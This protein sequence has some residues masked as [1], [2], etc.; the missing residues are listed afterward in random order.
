MNKNKFLITALVVVLCAGSVFLIKILKPNPDEVLKKRI[1]ERSLVDPKAPAWVTEYFDYQCPPC[2]TAQK[3]L[4][5][6]IAGHPGKIYLQVRYFPFP[7]H[8]HAMKAAI[9]A[10]CASRQKGKFWKFHEALF[11]HQAEWA[12]EAYPELKFLTYAQEAGLELTRWNACSKDPE[13]EKFVNEERTKADAFGVK[14]T[15]SFFVNGKMI[16]GIKALTE[17]LDAIVKQK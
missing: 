10:E 13:V 9:Y 3:T 16:V 11:D 8:L 12:Q 4:H 1:A 17:E 5:D 6:W 7:K 15:P 2:G 14:L